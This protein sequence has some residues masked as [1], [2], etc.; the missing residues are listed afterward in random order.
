MDRV[1]FL[2]K[3]EVEGQD[4]ADMVLSSFDQFMALYCIVG[5]YDNTNITNEGNLTFTISF[6]DNSMVDK[7]ISIIGA[8]G[9]RILIYERNFGI[10]INWRNESQINL[11]IS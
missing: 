3:L 1:Q 6:D 4:F 7:L 9:N 2:H 10:T 11:T 8:N 5:H